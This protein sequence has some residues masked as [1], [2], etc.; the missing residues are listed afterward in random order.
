MDGSGS[1]P[2]RR[3]RLIRGSALGIAL[4]VV[5]VAAWAGTRRG[6]DAADEAPD[7]VAVEEVVPAQAS[8][9][10]ITPVVGPLQKALRVNAPATRRRAAEHPAGPDLRER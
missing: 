4:A 10:P 8:P 5:G 9:R 7:D 1:A 3:S 6:D 2:R